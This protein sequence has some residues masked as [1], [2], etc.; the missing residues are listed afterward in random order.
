MTLTFSR[1]ATAFAALAAA[2]LLAAGCSSSSHP[3]AATPSVSA[4]TAAAPV[5]KAL[6]KQYLDSEKTVLTAIKTG[7]DKIKALKQ[8]ASASDVLAALTPMENATKTFDQQLVA[9]PWPDALKSKVSALHDADTAWLN[10]AAG[11]NGLTGTVPRGKVTDTLDKP[12]DQQVA[13]V[14][15]L[16]AAMNLP[17]L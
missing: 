8:P 11:L 15:H 1:S 2:G 10:A 9:M 14:D 17:A 12:Y 3:S 13:A 7:A 5:P 16:R 6:I 4:T